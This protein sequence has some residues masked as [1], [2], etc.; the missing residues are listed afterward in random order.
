MKPA[1]KAGLQPLWRDRDTLQIGVDPR[2]AIALTGL[3]KAAA[4]VSLLDG[5]RD[6]AEVVST[7]RAYGI[8]P[9]ATNRVLGL[10]ASAG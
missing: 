7:A 1:V 6:A 10:L 4:V 3:G 2:R 8:P 5:S 9:D